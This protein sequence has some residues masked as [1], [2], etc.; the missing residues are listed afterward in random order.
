M[1][2]LL[3]ALAVAGLTAGLALFASA[4]SSPRFAPASFWPPV[5]IYGEEGRKA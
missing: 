2:G 1:F 5:L 4:L 3:F